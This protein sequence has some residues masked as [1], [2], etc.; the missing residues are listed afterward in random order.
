M[1]TIQ[2]QITVQIEVG[3]CP[4]TTMGRAGPLSIR[5]ARQILERATAQASATLEKRHP[6]WYHSLFD[7]SLFEHEGA[8]LMDR[9]VRGGVM[10]TPADLARCWFES[11]GVRA[12]ERRAAYLRELE[13]IAAEFLHDLCRALQAAQNPR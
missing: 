13:P 11:T 9:W 8:P 12:P 2:K 6:E 3:S 7:A 4:T 5:R 1:Q 10:P